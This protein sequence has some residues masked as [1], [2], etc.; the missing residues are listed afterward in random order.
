MGRKNKEQEEQHQKIR[1]A[2]LQERSSIKA[3]YNEVIEKTTATFAT[4]VKFHI[5]QLILQK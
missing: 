2:Y 4:E 1:H 5:R 3:I